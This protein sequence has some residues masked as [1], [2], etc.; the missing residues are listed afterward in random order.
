MKV[1]VTGCGRSGTG[2][3]A[4]A[5]QHIGLDV[6]HEEMGKDGT[7]DWKEVAR[8]TSLE[9]EHVIQVVRDPLPWIG[10]FLTVG[11]SSW[12]FIHKNQGTK[13]TESKIKDCL[14]HWIKWNRWANR[15]CDVVIRLDD[16]VWMAG[17]IG[18]S[19]DKENARNHKTVELSQILEE[20]PLEYMIAESMYCQYG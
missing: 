10:S 12:E 2:F 5:L 9:Y 8:T 18:A 6:R 17:M 15:I 7:S 19:V 4:K 1:L 11:D 14:I 13:P 16:L 20:A 3:A